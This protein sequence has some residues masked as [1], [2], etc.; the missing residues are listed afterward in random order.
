MRVKTP[1]FAAKK[2]LSTAWDSSRGNILHEIWT[3]HVCEKLVF[4]WLEAF[5][6]LKCKK[7]I[8]IYFNFI[9]LL[10]INNL[11]HLCYSSIMFIALSISSLFDFTDAFLL[12][13]CWYLIIENCVLS[14]C[15]YLL[16][17]GLQSWQP[18]GSMH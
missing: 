18:G 17:V 15:G 10:S 6:A 12:G 7:K 11:I 4:S 16:L 9:H 13:Q 2:C 3:F 14:E 8:K 5:F 1:H